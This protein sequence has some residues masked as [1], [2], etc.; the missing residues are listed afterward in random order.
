LGKDFSAEQ[1]CNA[2]MD[3]VSAH[4]LTLE[5]VLRIIGDIEEDPLCLPYISKAEKRRKL[6][7]LRKLL[8]T[9][10]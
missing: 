9:L 8:S 3:V 2:I 5:R 10:A 7:R 6:K 1:I 4:Q